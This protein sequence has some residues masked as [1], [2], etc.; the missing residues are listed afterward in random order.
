MPSHAVV[1]TGES[2]LFAAQKAL[3]NGD[4]LC[5]PVDPRGSVVKG[6][7]RLLIFGLHVPGTQSEH[8]TTSRQEVDC[9]SLSRHQHR[10]A[11]VIVEHVGTD[12][13]SRRCLSGA[14]ERRH[15][16]EEVSEVIGDG[17]RIVAKA[18]NLAGF[19]HPFDPRARGPDIHAEPERRHP[20]SCG[21][22][23]R[24]LWLERLGVR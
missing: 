7:P 13:E 11:E 16:R 23:R 12:P 19:L 3:D 20:S 10:V 14:D 4:R 5:Q 8:E 18:L 22:V 6:Q 24:T 15:W 17:Q 21:V 1:L 9:R 2:D